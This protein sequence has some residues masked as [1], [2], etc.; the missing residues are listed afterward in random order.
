[1]LGFVVPLALLFCGQNLLEVFVPKAAVVSVIHGVSLHEKPALAATSVV[2]PLNLLAPAVAT[3]IHIL[4]PFPEIVVLRGSLQHF[5]SE[6][7]L[8]DGPLSAVRATQLKTH[9]LLSIQIEYGC[10]YKSLGAIST[11]LF[12]TKVVV[13]FVFSGSPALECCACL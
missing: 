7:K 8:T 1:V 2:P 10:K 4:S 11:P 9:N 5:T 12:Q 6:G 3:Q 13:R